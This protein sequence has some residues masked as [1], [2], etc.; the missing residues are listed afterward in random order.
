VREIETIE[1]DFYLTTEFTDFTDEFTGSEEKSSEF[2]FYCGTI[3]ALPV[4][5]VQPVVK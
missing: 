2:R 5:S 3:R 4:S 1:H